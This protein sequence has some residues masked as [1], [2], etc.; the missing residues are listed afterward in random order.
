M[1]RV[2]KSPLLLILLLFGFLSSAAIAA[3]TISINSGGGIPL[4]A[5][6]ATVGVCDP[7]ITM[8]ASTSLDPSTSLM[9]V[10]AITVG[11]LDMR[12][13]EGCA[14][15][16]LDLAYLLNGTPTYASFNIPSIGLSNTNFVLGSPS[17][18][19]NQANQSLNSFSAT[20]LSSVSISPNFSA[21]YKSVSDYAGTSIVSSNLV[22]NL[23]ASNYSGSGNWINTGTAGGVA[24]PYLNPA[25]TSYG[26]GSC[27]SF[28][29]IL[30]HPINKGSQRITIANPLSTNM[31]IGVWF[32]MV[33][34]G[35]GSGST[36]WGGKY[37][38]WDTSFLVDGDEPNA[39][40]FGLGITDGHIV[41]GTG[42]YGGSCDDAQ[43]VQAI[44]NGT[45][46][47]GIWHYV[48]VTRSTSSQNLEIYV[49]GAIVTITQNGNSS[50]N[51][52]YPLN[53]Q[54]T[55]G[56]GGEKNGG[57]QFYGDKSIASVQMYDRVLTSTE[58]V[59][60]YN[61]M[62]SIFGR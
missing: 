30:N 49:D 46:N 53:G 38:F 34:L 52:S 54:S 3:T 62:R 61:A 22:V 4:G 36:K 9:K 18:A 43:D 28:M 25:Y 12:Y 59:Q 41:W 8:S 56:I 39:A 21:S 26:G 11:N 33:D 7:D 6:R 14:G 42:C 32:K 37:R 40:D 1:R 10:D 51:P 35:E 47:D 5:G 13:P 15:N 24:T 27:F 48:A 2:Y 31:T 20:T 60:N 44:S 45:Y 57:R 23:N 19:C 50:A 58:I 55:L 16:V 29:T 17:N